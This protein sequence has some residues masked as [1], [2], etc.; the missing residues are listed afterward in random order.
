MGGK[1]NKE[2]VGWKKIVKVKQ[3][4]FKNQEDIMYI[5]LVRLHLETVMQ[6]WSIYLTKNNNIKSCST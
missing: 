2:L 5:S 1:N 6:F 3:K 4:T